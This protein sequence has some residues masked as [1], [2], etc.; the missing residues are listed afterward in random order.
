MNGAARRDLFLWGV[1]ALNCLESRI[2]RDG[3]VLPGGILKVDGFL[4]HQMDVTLF[5]EMAEEFHR[6]FSS[7]GVN[8]IL[9]IEASGI[10]LAC[11]TGRVF[12]CPVL[13]A[14]KHLT[15]N[16]AGQ[17]YTAQVA[18]FTHGCTYTI[19]V[20]RDFL[21]PA[22]RVLIIDDFLANGEALKGLISLAEQAGAVVVGAGVAVEK[23]FQPGGEAVR[24]M[25]Y[26]V[27][28][29]ARIRSMEDGKITFC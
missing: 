26:R 27:K 7:C 14:K 2:L 11:I 16:L 22:D 9:T 20:S 21:S 19:V 25:G 29:L 6:A 13:F 1:D 8:K 4:N 3:R 23:A 24:A 28:A 10:G 17:F 5:E 12:G 15:K 18:S